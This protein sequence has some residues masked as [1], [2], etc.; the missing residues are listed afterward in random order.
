MK[1][2]PI[3]KRGQLFI[4]D[5][6]E[7]CPT[8]VYTM[9][10]EHHVFVVDTFLGQSYLEPVLAYLKDFR[11]T[12]RTVIINTHYDWDHIWGNSAFPHGL[13]IAHD[14][15]SKQLGLHFEKQFEENH[16]YV[17]DSIIMP[18][19]SIT[20]S[21]R[22]TFIGEGIEIFHSPGHTS[23]SISIYDAKDEIL[24]V[25]DNVEEPEPYLNDVSKE[26]FIETLESYLKYPFKFLIAGHY[27]SQYDI[28]LR[29]NLQK[30]RIKS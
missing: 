6:L 9:I 4:F 8:H 22:M 1:Q 10:G 25:G 2:V 16:E 28:M 7:E 26:V 14:T 18:I 29:E 17:K 3:G 11:E 12:R 23:D 15:F 20:F 30:L 5:D 27:W 24:L 19:P 21:E 13:F